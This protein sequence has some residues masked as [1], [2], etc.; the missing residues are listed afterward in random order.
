MVAGALAGVASAIRSG[1]GPRA[2]ARTRRAVARSR[3]PAGRPCVPTTA[4]SRPRAAG[5]LPAAARRP[6]V[7]ETITTLRIVARDV[8]EDIAARPTSSDPLEPRRTPHARRAEEPAIDAS[9][10]RRSAACAATLRVACVGPKRS[11][12]RP[13]VNPAP[14]PAVQGIGVRHWSRFHQGKSGPAR[15]AGGSTTLVGRDRHVAQPELLAVVEERRAAEGQQQDRGG[16]RDRVAIGR[17]PADVREPRRV[18]GLIVVREH[19]RR[20]AAAPKAAS[21]AV[22]GRAHGLGRPWCRRSAPSRRRDGHRRSGPRPS[23]DR[24]VEQLADGHPARVARRGSPGT[25]PMQRRE[26]RLVAVVTWT[27]RVPRGR[28][29]SRRV[30]GQVGVLEEDVEDVEPEAVDA[31]VEPAADHPELGGLDRR[32]PPVQLG[33]LDE[34]RVVVELLALAA[35]TPSPARRRTRPSCSV[36]AGSPSGPIPAGRATGTSRRTG[37]SGRAATPRTSDAGRSCGS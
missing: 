30:R 3:S 11:H 23:P 15:R 27:W 17:S 18:A 37:P 12:G 1:S 22:D 35:P 26:V 10:E 16:R 19:E 8:G 34:E 20:P 9:T 36:A 31:A 6:E 2:A 33:L 13:V 5:Q 14:G 28:P 4:A 24:P 21:R 7:D 32:R 29:R 25:A